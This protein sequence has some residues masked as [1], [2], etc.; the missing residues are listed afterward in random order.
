M[1]VSGNILEAFNKLTGKDII[2]FFRNCTSF[3]QNGYVNIT[4]YYSGTATSVSSD[5]F[6]TFN[7]LQIDLFDIFGAFHDHSTQMKDSRWWDLLNQIE[8]IDSRF[9]TLRNINKWARSS[10]TKVSYSPSVQINY[11]LQQQ[12]TLEGVARDVLGEGDWTD[13][14]V[15][16]ALDN[17]LA[18]EDYSSTSGNSLQLQI[19]ESVNLK[20]VVNSVVAALVGQSI[21][22]LDL[23]KNFSYDPS[24]N[25]IL[26]LDNQDTILQA[27][28]ILIG[29]KRNDNPDNPNNGLQQDMIVGGNR[30]L[31]N[32][33]TIIRQLTA[34]FATDDTFKDFSISN[35]SVNQDNLF[36]TFTVM[37]RLN[38]VM[39]P[40]QIQL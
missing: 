9:A 28:Y 26:V 5:D 20:I 8:Q 18:E 24:E 34:A 23:N 13:S 22:G 37:N 21:L 25:D 30:A 27:A 14:W 16:I 4:S 11:T 36:C 38:E 3:F 10:V 19:S 15:N 2:A 1:V 17:D 39:P 7:N 31:L 32:F 33:P 12:Q 6:N 29:L 35:L 40:I